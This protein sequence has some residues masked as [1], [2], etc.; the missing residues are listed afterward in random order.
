MNGI[1]WKTIHTYNG[2]QSGGFEEL[3]AQLARSESPSAAKFDRKGSPDAGVECFCVLSDGSEWGWQAKYFFSLGAPQMTELDRSVKTALDKHPN[4][5]RY[6][7][8]T[9]MDRPDARIPGRMSAL[10]RWESYVKKWEDWAQAR[11]MKV[12]F[13]WWGSSELIERL[14]R[15]D[16]VGRR[17]FWFGQQ[18][19]DQDWFCSRLN[20]AVKAAGPRYTPEIHVDLPI[21]Q[22]LD[23]FSRS[24]RT[25][26]EV[27]S[28]AVGIRRAH[29]GL[30]RARGP[31][32]EPALGSDVDDL[33][34]ATSS[35]LDTLTQLEP[36]P[37]G[38]VPLP[39]IV[40]AAEEAGSAA[41]QVLDRMG[42]LHRKWEESAREGRTSPSYYDDL[43]RSLNF[44][45][46]S[47][48][49]ELQKLVG[50]GNRANSLANSQLLLLTG[51]GG[52]GKT[53]LLC[54]FAKSRARNQL[55][56][57]LLMGQ[58]FLSDDEPWTQALHSLD[59]A[60]TSAE[61]FLGALE[62]AAQ[63]SGCRALIIV[64]A[65]NEGNGRKIWQPNLSAFL[66]RA[67]KSP[68]IG[69]VIS[70]RSSYEEV[71][72]PENVRVRAAHVVHYGFSD[73]EYDAVKAFFAH[74]GLEFPSAP[75]LQPEF[76]NPL[77]LKTICKGLHDSGE[78]RIPK[79][80]NGI[81]TAFNLYLKGINDRLASQELLDFDA[82]DNLVQKAL[83]GIAE[84][85]ATGETRWLSRSDAQ[86][87]VN[88]FLPG[89]DYSRSLFSALIAE[90][91]LTEDVGWWS[92]DLSEEV[93]FITYDR[94]ADHFICD[95]L[96]T[97]FLDA[98]DPEPA[99]AKG[100][101]LAF[102]CDEERYVPRGLIEA[103]NIQLPERT[104]KELASLVP[105][106]LERPDF[107][108]AFLQSIIWR[109]HEA[110]SDDT[111]AVLNDLNQRENISDDLL[112]TLISVST[113]P[114]HP[115]NADCLHNRLRKDSMPDRDSWWSTYL[116][117][118]WETQGPVDRL[119]DWASN[120][121]V[122]DNLEYEVVDLAATTL[123]WM[124]ATPNR[125]LRDRATKALVVLLTGRMEAAERLVNRFANVDDPYVA[126]RVYA[127]VYGVAMR[128]NDAE[129]V[130]KLA[131]NVYGRVFASGTPPPHV[132]LRDYARGVAERAIHL[133]YD[134][135]IDEHLIH[136]P[137]NR[138]WPNIPSGDEIDALTP[139]QDRGARDNGDLEWSRNRIRYS[140]MGQVLGDFAHYVIGTDSPSNWLSLR[141][142]EEFWQ[143]PEQ[144]LHALNSDFSEAERLAWNDFQTAK[145]KIPPV[146]RDISVNFVD[147]AGTVVD[148]RVFSSPRIDKQTAEQVRV[149]SEFACARLIEEMTDEHRI[150]WDAICREMEDHDLRDGPRFDKRLVQRYI[151]WRV[152][153]L[154]WTVDRFGRFDRFDVPHV[155]RNRG[156]GG[157]HG[158]KVPMDRIS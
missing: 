91:I 97:A 84:R 6:F 106:V 154:G 132:L 86:T 101:R 65:L 116:H 54:D 112:D 142:N 59:L 140:V 26:K 51:D 144:R 30:V 157:A 67:E 56:T 74:Y 130:G 61:E 139:N 75:I 107:T 80:F 71:V 63:A 58:R 52:T 49:S 145:S 39:K 72:I 16:H 108:Y 110:F 32:E 147:K 36:C 18:E 34:K 121:S 120:L 94:F 114:G 28:L 93:V 29:Q 31:L 146:V 102:L 151:L 23:R 118:S 62:A 73:H 15:N 149:N 99:F 90:G 46:I 136:P 48:H 40:K 104:G 47:L 7:V 53:H 27:K 100:G 68:W 122:D 20:E 66:E 1:D 10:Q 82:K 119:V 81:T 125:F 85:L 109:K 43:G 88:A 92:E 153:D 98:A 21:A 19:F 89:R 152:F 55:P 129:A 50:I 14:S 3:C 35:V 64:D 150:E 87:L 44:Y 126:E 141:L 134:L 4:L 2:S 70:V 8:C 137:Y 83:D 25:F 143:S 41:S 148:N 113:V 131:L 103:L 115:L 158:K 127:V 111:L 11:C 77:F 37:T 57:I 22:D 5:V 76:K 69:V 96:L 45:V 12:E 42:E 78:R 155:G 60:G 135:C 79:G 9:P 38:P 124:F 138:D 95:H 13:V 123:A 24:D 133:G 17:R 33:C 128:S 156:Q 105:N 117:R